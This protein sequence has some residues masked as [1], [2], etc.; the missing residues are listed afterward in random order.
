MKSVWC[1]YTTFLRDL[2]WL[3]LS[4]AS[5]QKYCKGF[6]GVIVAVPVEQVRQFMY[7]ESK[8]GTRDRPVW[9]RGY[10]EVPDK[11]FVNHLAMKC[12]ADILNPEATHILHMDPDCLWCKPTTPDTYFVDDKPVLVIEPFDVVSQY[13]PG[14]FNWKSGVERALGFT[15]DYETMCR[16]PAVHVRELYPAVRAHIEKVHR[17]PFFDYV[18]RCQNKFPQGFAEYPTLGAYAIKYMPEKYVFVDCGPEKLKHLPEL[19][20]DHEIPYG[21]PNPHIWQGWSYT[22]VDSPKNQDVIK[23]ILS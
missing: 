19:Q 8:Y 7:L 4:L 20:K 6:E 23:S 18:I 11:G 9:I 10:Y 2:K 13:H 21:H 3:D 1:N 12:S 14:R 16:H 15:C 17:T 5:M 22:G